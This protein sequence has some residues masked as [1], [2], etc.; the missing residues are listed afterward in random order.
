MATPIA[1]SE[2]YN[3][4]ASDIIPLKIFHSGSSYILI[5]YIQEDIG[6]FEFNEAGVKRG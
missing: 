5:I 4:P 1:T 6:I 2:R 3:Y